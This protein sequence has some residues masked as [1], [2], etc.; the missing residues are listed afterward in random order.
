M[1]GVF[2]W[3]MV[4]SGGRWCFQ[5]GD[6]VFR[7]KMVFSGGIWC[8]QVGDGVFRWKMEFGGTVTAS[9]GETGTTY[10]SGECVLA[11]GE[12]VT[13]IMFDTKSA[14][15]LLAPAAIGFLTNTEQFCGPYGIA[16]GQGLRTYSGRRLLFIRGKVGAVNDW[17]EFIFADCVE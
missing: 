12:Y 11:E 7:W 8:F 15:G 2:R 14:Y 17:V 9:T 13:T 6:G 5:V 10:Q 3:K 4:F 16:D 1:R